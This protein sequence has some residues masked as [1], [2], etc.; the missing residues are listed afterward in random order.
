MTFLE[1]TTKFSNFEVFFFIKY[2]FNKFKK[3]P[4]VTDLKWS[5]GLS[6]PV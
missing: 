1:E 6:A 2:V 3:F 4:Y 5:R